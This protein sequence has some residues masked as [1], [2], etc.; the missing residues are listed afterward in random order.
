MYT[1]PFEKDELWWGGAVGRAYH[2][3]FSEQ[4]DY[5]DDYRSTGVL[6]QTMPL[7][8]SDHGRYIWSESPF[9]VSI[10]DGAFTFE[11]GQAE[12]VKAGTCL[13]DAYLAAM[14]AHFPFN[15]KH[16]PEV[17]FRT[18][19]YNSWMEFTY[20]PTQDGILDYARQIIE[21]G[22]E[23]GILIIDEGWHGR[24]GSWKFDEAR[25]P[26]PKAMID[27]LHRMGFIVMLWVVPWVCADG[28]DFVVA[29]R[30]DLNPKKNADRLFIRNKAGEVALFRWWNGYSALLNFNNPD[31]RAFLDEKLRFLIDEYGVDGFKFDGGSVHAYHPSR[32]INGPLPDDYDPHDNNRAWLEFGMAYKYHE[33]KDAYGAGGK[34]CIQRLLDRGHR[35]EN[36]GINTL[37][38]C[39]I[40]QGLT[41]HPFICPDMIGG[42]EWSFN[43]IPGFKIDSELFVRMAQLSA[44]CPM[45]QF[46]WAPW[47][48]LAPEYL[49][50]VR[51]AA[52]LHTQMAEE[53]LALVA[54]SEQNGEPILRNLEYNDPGQGYGRIVDQFMVGEDILVAPVVT[55]N[56][57]VRNVV[58]P[59]G[60]WR[61]E[62]GNTWQGRQTCRVDAPLSKLLWFRRVK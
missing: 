3:P 56:T 24:Y 18:A 12:V 52:K 51:D 62:D 42:G 39:S 57:T 21:N 8:V 34:N 59:A 37:I 47:R 58:F 19:Q 25:F 46:S 5:T 22:F 10:K 61:D 55:P 15:G 30:N 27:E 29:T 9:M 44:L 54:E 38:P 49:E 1:I 11:G 50:M 53:L 31:D 45:M 40:V 17:F 14:Q 41:G 32:V 23:P 48:V 16:L 20:F 60:T 36:D 28:H 2:Q 33:Y 35:W 13:R 26:N 6:N 4:S 43:R 7:F